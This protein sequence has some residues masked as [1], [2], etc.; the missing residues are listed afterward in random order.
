MPSESGWL[1]ELKGTGGDEWL[2]NP[3]TYFAGLSYADGIITAL[4]T[5]DHL[6][7]VRFARKLDAEHAAEGLG[8]ETTV[9]DHIWDD[10]R[11]P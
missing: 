8:V 7:A 2:R 10:V 5:T 11:L 4:W 1:I 9:A 3:L 6:R